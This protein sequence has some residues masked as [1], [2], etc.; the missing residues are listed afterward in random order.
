MNI[1]PIN[2]W[3]ILMVGWVG[4]GLQYYLFVPDI[5]GE[6]APTKWYPYKMVHF[7]GRLGGGGFTILFVC[8]RYF[9]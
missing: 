5:F 7:D 2:S 9:W 1:L 6:P 4:A 8:A 3:Y